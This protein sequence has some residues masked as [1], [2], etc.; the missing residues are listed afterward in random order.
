MTDAEQAAI[1]Y[2][3][4]KLS[5]ESPMQVAKSLETAEFYFRDVPEHQREQAIIDA[6]ARAVAREIE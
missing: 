5:G 6:A 4:D 3:S 2:L 1:N